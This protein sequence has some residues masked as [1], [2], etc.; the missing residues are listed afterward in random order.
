MEIE[1]RTLFNIPSENYSKF[2]KMMAKLSKR[3]EKL[4]GLPIT[5]VVFGYEMQEIAGHQHKVY[6]V[7]LTAETPKIDG[8]T[9]VAR[10]D[11]SNETGN[12]IRM[13]PNTGITLPET[14]RHC[15]PNCDHCRIRR[16]R[17]DTFVIH[18]DETGEFKQVGSS[19]LVD[20]FGHDPS[21]IAKLAEILGYAWEGAK[22]ASEDHSG[23]NDHRWLGVEE[24]LGHVACMIRHHGWTSASMAHED[25]NLISTKE[26]ALNNMYN[27]RM[28]VSDGDMKLASDALEWA[29]SLSSKNNMSDF[30][31]NILM[32]A[33][34]EMIEFRSAGLAAAIVGVYWKNNNKPQVQQLGN[35]ADILK[36]FNQAGSKLQ[37]PKMLLSLGGVD[38]RM[39]MTGAKSKSPGCIDICSTDGD[40]D[41]RIWYGRIYKDGV[42]RPSNRVDHST[43][44]AINQALIAFAAD[45]VGVASAYGKKTG[46]CCFCGKALT[47]ERSVH[48][49]YG[50]TCAEHYGLPWGQ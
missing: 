16:L 41:S 1:N 5:P 11:H 33:D 10:L 8:W 24:Y 9:F 49:G 45:P 22:A 17:R 12:I 18:N 2:E 23:L 13:V 38:V 34:A 6:Q 21:K 15:S 44:T 32:V 35:V 48:V 47:D 19:C 43:Q 50:G 25:A 46:H 14:Y 26:M 37:Y 4:I 39:S 7:Y 30:E 28:V 31:H 29:R 42:F 20:F 40:Y 27:N 36:L 3:S